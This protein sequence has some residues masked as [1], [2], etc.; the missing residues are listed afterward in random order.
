MDTFPQISAVI[1]SGEAM[2][3]IKI[4]IFLEVHGSPVTDSS[5][6]LVKKKQHIFFFCILQTNQP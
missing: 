3:W 1:N 5:I 2:D 4:E 6:K